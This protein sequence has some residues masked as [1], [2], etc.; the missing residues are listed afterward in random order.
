VNVLGVDTFEQTNFTLAVSF[1]I[2]NSQIK[3]HLD[4]DASQVRAE[5]VQVFSDY[6][7]KV[8]AL[9]AAEPTSGYT[10][11][12][13]LSQPERQQLLIEWNDT[14]AEFPDD[15][16]IHEL[17]EQQVE[18]TPEAV[19][20]V[21]EAE[22]VSYRELNERANQLAHY[23]RQLGVGPEERVGICVERSVEMVVGLLGILKAGGAYVPLDAQYPEERLRFM[24]ADAQVGVLLTQEQLLARLPAHEAQVV[25]LDRDWE[26]IG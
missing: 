20:L 14:G 19:A 17:F 23:L 12:C 18:R 26:E 8:L 10:S 2:D 21:Y 3:L 22:Q 16:C 25:C 13:L 15:Q 7:G 6:F 11:Q 5:Q 4:Y 9:M 1:S 24:L